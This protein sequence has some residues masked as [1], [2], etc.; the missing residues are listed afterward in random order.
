MNLNLIP[1]SKEKERIMLGLILF[2]EGN[3][4]NHGIHLNHFYYADYKKIFQA[5]LD[6]RELGLHI[7]EL[8]VI[9]QLKESKKFQD[10]DETI[11]N[12]LQHD[13]AF[14]QH[15]DEYLK[16]LEMYRKRRIALQHLEKIIAEPE[17]YDNRKIYQTM[18]EVEK[19]ISSTDSIISSKQLSESKKGER[20]YSGIW[21]IDEQIEMELQDYIIIGADPRRGK[22]S[23]ALTMAYRMQKYNPLF[24]SAEMGQARIKQRMACIEQDKYLIE[25][26]NID[27]YEIQSNIHWVFTPKI[28]TSQID[29]QVSEA[30]NLYKTKVIYI[31][32][33]QHLQCDIQRGAIFKRNDIVSQISNDL[34]AIAKKHNVLLIACSQLNREAEK[35]KE[36]P[37]LRSLKESGTI[38]ADADIVLLLWEY[39]IG[40]SWANEIIIAK[41]RQGKADPN[42]PITNIHFE[43][44]KFLWK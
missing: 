37:N 12:G 9:E 8:T 42:K 18:L 28:H 30:I 15:F 43:K 7:D 40:S 1:A 5:M 35:A 34:L 17:K 2:S 23:L 4:L 11:I 29:M 6:L 25:L 39:S 26:K 19:V 10:G 24:F 13:I 36:K 41:Q 21:Q 14:H 3:Y 16:Y 44:A 32:H 20:L 38:E 22:T 33:I 27:D 31:D